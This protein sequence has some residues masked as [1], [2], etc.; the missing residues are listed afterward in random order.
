MISSRT[1]GRISEGNGDEGGGSDD[2]F[3]MRRMRRQH[4]AILPSPQPPPPSSSSSVTTRVSAHYRDNGDDVSNDD[5]DDYEDIRKERKKWENIRETGKKLAE[6]KHIPYP[7]S[8]KQRQTLQKQS[9]SPRSSRAPSWI[10]PSQTKEENRLK[11]LFSTQKQ[12]PPPSTPPAATIPPPFKMASVPPVSQQRQYETVSTNIVPPALLPQYVLLKGDKGDEG[13]KGDD[14]KFVMT[15]STLPA[16]RLVSIFSGGR[17]K[18]IEFFLQTFTDMGQIWGQISSLYHDSHLDQTSTPK[19]HCPIVLSHRT[20]ASFQVDLQHYSV[21]P[22]PVPSGV[23]HLETPITGTSRIHFNC[24]PV[25]GKAN[26]S[27]TSL[28]GYSCIITEPCGKAKADGNRRSIVNHNNVYFEAE[29]FPNT[30]KNFLKIK[31]PVE[32]YANLW[33]LDLRVGHLPQPIEWDLWKDDN[34]S[35]GS[36]KPKVNI[37]SDYRLFWSAHIVGLY[38]DL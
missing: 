22:F 14:A 28:V 2:D 19:H 4:H 6:Q 15:T 16:G 27:L 10:S 38:Y 7:S 30:T 29:V 9:S 24:L 23:R 17:C 25:Y 36:S 20:F 26:S 8:P 5:D 37:S 21:P 33:Y 12:P 11:E 34:N 18:K 32:D 3:D 35:S 1:F 31:S 13:K